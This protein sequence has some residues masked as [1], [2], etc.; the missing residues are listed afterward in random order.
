[1]AVS[2]SWV[3]DLDLRGVSEALAAGKVT[4]VEATEAYLDRIARHDG[5]LRAY[6]TV[7][8]DAA[9]ARARAADAEQSGG[10]RRGHAARCH[11]SRRSAKSVPTAAFARR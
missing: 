8:G 7:M 5:V 11:R 4:S 10:R 9:R 3:C 6:I 1:M 2:A